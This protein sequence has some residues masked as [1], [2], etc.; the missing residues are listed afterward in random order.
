MIIAK[1]VHDTVSELS[2]RKNRGGGGR[3]DALCVSF[4]DDNHNGNL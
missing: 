3:I 4:D 1:S 2:M